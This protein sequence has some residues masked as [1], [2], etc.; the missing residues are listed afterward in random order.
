MT[1]IDSCQFS[2]ERPDLLRAHASAQGFD[3]HLHD[4]FS[5]V[6]LQK[7]SAT[8][9]SPRGN[10]PVRA[11]DVFVCNPFEVHSGGSRDASVEYD[12]LYPSIRFARECLGTALRGG[13]LPI[14][15][16]ILVRPSEATRA[17]FEAVQSR[18]R[19]GAAAE[20]ALCRI[21][22]ECKVDD[23]GIPGRSFDAVNTACQIIH[24]HYAQSLDTE[25]LAREVGLHT[26]HFIRVFHRLTG[27]APQAYLRQ[28]RV[29][30]ARQLIC[31]GAELAAVACL[32]G[33]CD[34]A[35][36][37]REFKKI[38]GTTPGRFAR[39]VSA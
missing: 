5:V 18:G 26:S 9:R 21:F 20:N 38:H 35:H 2:L 10:Q 7:G 25:R 23:S 39:E 16:T 11:G 1:V 32:T 22:Q 4:T 37:T 12:V 30:R 28:V 13:L 8:V 15:R 24:E 31:A 3:P 34:Q 27:L 14:L 17:L 33:F 29:S 19:T 36:L 6:L